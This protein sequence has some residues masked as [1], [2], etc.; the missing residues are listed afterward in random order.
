M[1]REREWEAFLSNDQRFYDEKYGNDGTGDAVCRKAGSWSR[2]GNAGGNGRK[3]RHVT[4]E[5]MVTGPHDENRPCGLYESMLSKAAGFTIRGV[6]WYQGESDDTHPE[7][8][9]KL[10][11]RLVEQL[12]KDWQRSFRL[13]AQLAPFERW[14]QCRGINSR[15]SGNNSLMHG[16]I[17]IMCI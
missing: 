2:H 7:I 5:F 11:T 15:N 12:R 9:E 10:F 1:R 13:Y 4:G 17:L 8:Y 14:M 16:S 6:I 3:Q